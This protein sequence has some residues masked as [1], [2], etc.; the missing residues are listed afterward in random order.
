MLDGFCLY[1]EIERMQYLSAI[2]SVICSFLLV[3]L[4]QRS[5]SVEAAKLARSMLENT[6]NS[7]HTLL[8]PMNIIILNASKQLGSE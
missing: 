1:D 8:Q 4:C 3:G 5:H 6:A 7:Y 2:D